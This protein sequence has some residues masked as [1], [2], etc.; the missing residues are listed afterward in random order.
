MTGTGTRDQGFQQPQMLVPIVEAWVSKGV[1][2]ENSNRFKPSEDPNRGD[3]DR[4]AH[5]RSLAHRN[6]PDP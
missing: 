3:I 6:A 5:S 1:K 4:V 2:L